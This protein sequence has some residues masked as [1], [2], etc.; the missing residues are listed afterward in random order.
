MDPGGNNLMSNYKQKTQT[1]PSIFL[2][3]QFQTKYITTR[4]ERLQH[5]TKSEG[6][7]NVIITT[8]HEL[9]DIKHGKDN[10][11]KLQSGAFYNLLVIGFYEINNMTTTSVIIQIRKK[12]EKKIPKINSTTNPNYNLKCRNNPYVQKLINNLH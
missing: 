11:S 6:Q 7:H 8:I 3:M 1:R 2:D 10:L 9:K 4:A 5:Y 12:R